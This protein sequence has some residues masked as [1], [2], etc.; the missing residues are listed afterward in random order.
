MARGLKLTIKELLIINKSVNQLK[1]RPNLVAKIMG[2]SVNAVWKAENEERVVESPKIE[3][4]P[5]KISARIKRT[6]CRRVKVS[7]IS[8]T[9]LKS[10]CKLPIIKRRIDQILSKESELSYV[11]RFHT[12][13]LKKKH[14][15]DRLE[16]TTKHISYIT[17]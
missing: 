13:P 7:G 5:P 15:Q 10:R 8:Y 3:G 2:Q 16:W 12:P 9:R 6:I 11:K 4:R 14:L 17:R 1:M